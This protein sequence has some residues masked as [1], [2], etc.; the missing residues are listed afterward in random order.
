MVINDFKYMIRVDTLYKS[1]GIIPV[2]KKLDLKVNA[3][4]LVIINGSN[5][6]GKTTL[7]LLLSSLIK[8]DSGNIEI[9]GI[10]VGDSPK[11]ARSHI[12]YVAH[13]PF[14]YPSLTIREN[15]NFFAKLHNI[16]YEDI[17]QIFENNDL[18]KLLGISDRLDTLVSIL[19]HGYKKRAGIACSLIHNPSVLL[20]DEPE[21]GLDSN[22]VMALMDMVGFLTN[23]N[24]SIL[25]TTH[26]DLSKFNVEYTHYILKNGQLI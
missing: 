8:P 2:I 18:L 17:N 6:S 21:T 19:S 14:L 24:K 10:N 13:E 15:L 26:T 3:G 22:G 23:I 11:I 25:M 1:Y 5:G 9:S 4:E 16:S 7:H 20:L 12:G